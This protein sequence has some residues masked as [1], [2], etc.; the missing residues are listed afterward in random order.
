MSGWSKLLTAAD[1]TRTQWD[2]DPG[3]DRPNNVVSIPQNLDQSM[4]VLRKLNNIVVDIEAEEARLAGEKD[5]AVDERERHLES[6]I[7][8][9]N[10]ELNTVGLKVCR[11]GCRE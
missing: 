8:R 9:L 3:D 4:G 11:G 2:F 7:E 6:L 5:R 1:K 10:Q